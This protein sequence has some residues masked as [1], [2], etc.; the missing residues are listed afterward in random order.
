MSTL[1][2]VALLLGLSQTEPDAVPPPPART[3]ADCASPVYAVDHLICADTV[4]SNDE[5]DLAL[6]YAERGPSSEGGPWLEDQRAWVARRAR[7]A[8]R[9]N[10]RPC[11]IQANAERRLVLSQA[12]GQG[13]TRFALCPGAAGATRL[14]L[15]FSPDVIAAFDTQGRKI[16]A[17]T[18]AAPDWEPFLRIS[19][20]RRLEF[21]RQD[22]M[23][24]RCRAV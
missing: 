13:D 17:A 15:I 19:S 8:F 3:S 11:V 1:L 23:I 4:L 18:V 22:G 20:A 12:S 16:F 24:L 10:Q 9:Q 6:L 14:S 21:R 5:D 2:L 7:C